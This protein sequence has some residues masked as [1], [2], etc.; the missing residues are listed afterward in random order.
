MPLDIC[1]N[2]TRIDETIKNS[3]VEI[4]G[5][6]LTRRD[7]DRNVRWEGVSNLRTAIFIGL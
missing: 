4:Q 3:E 6:N 1:V 5:Y 2:E 7:R